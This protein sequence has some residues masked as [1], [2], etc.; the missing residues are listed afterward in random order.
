[1]REVKGLEPHGKWMVI[2]QQFI[3][4][5]KENQK[6][7]NLILFPGGILKDTQGPLNLALKKASIQRYK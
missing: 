6:K 2:T 4:D 7:S 1:M 5:S 3:R